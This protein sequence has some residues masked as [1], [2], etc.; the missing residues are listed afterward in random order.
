MKI[1]A[2]HGSQPPDPPRP[3][4]LQIH[5]HRLLWPLHKKKEGSYRTTARRTRREEITWQ[6]QIKGPWRRIWDPLAAHRFC[7]L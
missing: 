2:I 5:R 1:D 3:D 4:G 7:S 6:Q